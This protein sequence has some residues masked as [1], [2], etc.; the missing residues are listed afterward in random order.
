V[1]S[2]SEARQART[3]AHFVDAAVVAIG[4][5]GIDRL[6]VSRIATLA[7]ASRPT[8]Y[9]YFGEVGGLLAE[10][11][12]A[13]GDAF[14]EWL[15]NPSVSLALAS[16]DEKGELEVMAEVFAVAHRIPELSEV[17]N[18]SVSEWWQTR[19]HGSEYV[20]LKVAWVVAARLGEILTYKV[21]NDVTQAVF[22]EHFIWK[23][24]HECQNPPSPLVSTA[25]PR[26]SDPVATTDSMDRRLMDA[27]VKVISTS[28]V[29]AASMTRISRT[30]R[31]T[32]G[33][34]YPRFSD[35][36]SLVLSAFEN[37]ITE[38]TNENMSQ[39]GPE[40]FGPDDFGLFVM[41]GLQSNRKI[42]RNFRVEAHLEGA[43]NAE[44][45]NSMRGTIRAT[46]DRVVLGLDQLPA[47]LEQKRAIAYWVH[48]IGIGMAILFNAGL[49]VDRLDHRM[50]TRDM[51]SALLSRP[52]SNPA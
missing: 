3:I 27:A 18:P 47:T 46:N 34:A 19:T 6:S 1:S 30:A 41:A 9:A 13:K 2:A 28:G 38:V 40:G 49:A 48:T 15:A 35:S 8:F 20:A 24:G 29:A 5:T 36:E 12:L 32:T 14:L 11:W 33:A 4:E 7:G 16:D 22:G 39:I 50:I 17:V 51:M 43:I 26:A 42:W 10:L 45:A 25:L 52:L 21:D 44:L 31:V 37:W 23:L